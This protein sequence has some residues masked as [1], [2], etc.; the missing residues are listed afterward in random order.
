M[1]SCIKIVDIR[2]CTAIHT[3]SDAQFQTSYGW[4]SSCFSPDGKY[5]GSGSSSNGLIF[6]WEA[7]SGKLIKKL[8]GHEGGVCG[9]VWGRGGTSGQQVASVDKKGILILWS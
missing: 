4:A 2:T 6:V 9:F 7:E 8:K 3:F 5:V 1:D